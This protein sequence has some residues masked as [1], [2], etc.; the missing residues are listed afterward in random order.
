MKNH[1]KK[2]LAEDL[3]E[4]YKLDSDSHLKETEMGQAARAQ[5]G[6]GAEMQILDFH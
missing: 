1:E 6:M 2:A 5:K 3:V 4:Q